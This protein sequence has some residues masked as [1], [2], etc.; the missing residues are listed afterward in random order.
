MV[1][2]E[3]GRTMGDTA[4]VVRSLVGEDIQDRNLLHLVSKVPEVPTLPANLKLVEEIM[5]GCAIRP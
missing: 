2:L 1:S 4:E 3:R 5:V